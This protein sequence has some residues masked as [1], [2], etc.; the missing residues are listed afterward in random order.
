[1]S[2]YLG[3]KVT[4]LK[5]VRIMNVKLDIPVGKYRDLSTE[6]LKEIHKLVANSAKTFDS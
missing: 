1:M 3:Y 4:K 5:R 2:E 6:E